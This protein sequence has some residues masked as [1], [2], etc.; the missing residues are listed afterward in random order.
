MTTIRIWM[1]MKVS[2]SLGERLFLRSCEV[3]SS[4]TYYLIVEGRYKNRKILCYCLTRRNAIQ[5]LNHAIYQHGYNS[6]RLTTSSTEP[7]KKLYF[8]P[9]T[10]DREEQHEDR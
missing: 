9:I 4:M 8:K 3:R 7:D 5:M 10:A 2:S 6:A 1:S